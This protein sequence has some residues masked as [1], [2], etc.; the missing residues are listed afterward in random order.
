MDIGDSGTSEMHYK[1]SEVMGAGIYT[2]LGFIIF[3]LFEQITLDF[4]FE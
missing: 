1:S 3:L 4:I 2:M